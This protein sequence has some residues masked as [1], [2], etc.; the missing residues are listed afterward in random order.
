MTTSF[1][2]KQNMQK[3]KIKL[4]IIVFVL[5]IV[6]IVFT[7]F[8]LLFEFIQEWHIVLYAA[9]VLF[10]VARQADAFLSTKRAVRLALDEPKEESPNS[11]VYSIQKKEDFAVAYCVNCG[12]NLSKRYSFCPK[13]GSC[14]VNKLS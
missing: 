1:S 9:G 14:K 3:E 13:C 11:K 4:A 12:A 8:Y 6:S 5:S 7:I 2:L 10:L